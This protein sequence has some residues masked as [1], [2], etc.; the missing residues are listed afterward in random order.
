MSYLDAWAQS[1][2]VVKKPGHDHGASAAL[3]FLPWLQDKLWGARL[4]KGAVT[5]RPVHFGPLTPHQ[6]QVQGPD[7][8][9][10]VSWNEDGSVLDAAEPVD[11]AI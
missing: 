6:G 1:H 3:Q 10:D 2:A 4:E 11:S 9:K 8:P 7:G 5:L